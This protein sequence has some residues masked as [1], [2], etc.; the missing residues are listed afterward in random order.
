MPV[1]GTHPQPRVQQKKHTSYSPQ[2]RRNSRHSLCDG[3]AAYTRSPRCPGL[4][5]T[6]ACEFVIRKLDP[7]VGGSG[8]RDFAARIKQRRLAPPEASTASRAQR[9]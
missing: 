6:V 1:H 7:G 3:S 8:P 2:V 4:L 5:A 9:P